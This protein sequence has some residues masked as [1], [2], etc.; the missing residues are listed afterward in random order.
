MQNNQ[1]DLTKGPVFKTLLLFSIPFVFSTLLQSVY[2]M[3]DMMIVG[4]YVGSSALSAVSVSSQ[5]VQLMTSICIGI[6]T[7][8]QIYIAQM[9]GAK[10]TEEIKKIV[11]NLTMMIL[12]VSVVLV[13]ISIFFCNPLLSLIDTPAEAFDQ[14]TTYLIICGAGM[15]FTAFYNMTSAV[16]RGMGDSRHPFMFIAV[17]SIL[18]IILDYILVAIFGM[19]VSGAALATVIGQAVSVIA[20]FIYL[21]KNQKTYY[22]SFERSIFKFDSRII[23]TLLKLGAPLALQSSAISISSLFVS[24][25]VNQLGVAASATFGSGQKIQSIPNIITQAVGYG[26]SSMVAQNL[27]AGNYDRIKKTIYSA[28][29]IT[30]IACLICGIVF[31]LYP[32][33]VFGLFT[34]D[35]DVLD[36]APAF[37]TALCVQLPAMAMMSPFNN[38]INGAG[39]T[40]L[41]LII[42]LADGFVARILLSYFLG[43]TMNMGAFGFFLGYSLAAY[44]TA[45]PGL[46][47]FLAGRYKKEAVA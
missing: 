14:A 24:K 35:P 25:L 17:A 43:I 32:T 19:G 16:F 26:V 20:S 33:Q 40:T 39:D 8:G 18:N 47:Y 12:I 22:I 1:G 29:S 42:G 13:F 41:S 30:S 10:R 11:G 31:Y 44:I 2:S 3:V 27:G 21:A 37:I 34:S 15:I 23:K 38:L 4:Q 5:I 9:L 36:L 28:L 45:I 46:I 6:A 7:A